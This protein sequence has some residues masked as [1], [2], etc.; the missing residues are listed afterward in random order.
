MS[1][2]DIETGIIQRVPKKEMELKNTY[3][4]QHRH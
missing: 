4:A 1:T 2:S 3:E